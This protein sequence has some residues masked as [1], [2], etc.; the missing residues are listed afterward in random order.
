MPGAVTF[1]SP[2]WTGWSD[3]PK[4]VSAIADI[5][6]NPDAAAAKKD[7]DALQEYMWAEYLPVSKLGDINY[8]DVSSAKTHGFDTSNGASHAW[9]MT[10][11]Q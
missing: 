4:V 7:W 8:Y 3:D 1:L 6:R 2:T 11:E 9:N 5:N 10:V